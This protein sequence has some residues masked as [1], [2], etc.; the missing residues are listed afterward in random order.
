MRAGEQYAMLVGHENEWDTTPKY[1]V[2]QMAKILK[3]SEHTVRYYDQIGFFP[4][5]ERDKNNVRLFS[6]TDAFFGRAVSCFREI[7]MPIKDC[8]RFVDLTLKGDITIKERAALVRKQEVKM[9]RELE[10]LQENLADIYYKRLFF[11]SLLP[12]IE[13]EIREGRFEEKGRSTLKKSRIYIQKNMYEDG[14]ID[15]IEIDIPLPDDDP[16]T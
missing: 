9:R 2:K 15:K 14:L 12:E 1:T 3:M 10:K 8:K 6:L 7:G 13:A 11:E 4:F 16:N 5:V